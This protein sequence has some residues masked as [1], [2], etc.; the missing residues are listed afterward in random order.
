VKGYPK[1]QA[2]VLAEF[3]QTV[4]ACTGPCH[5]KG[6]SSCPTPDACQ[7]PIADTPLGWWAKVKAWFIG[8]SNE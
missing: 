3:E 1:F 5:Q 2:T 6:G 7:L 8:D 4:S